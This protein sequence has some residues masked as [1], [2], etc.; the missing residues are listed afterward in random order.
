[1]CE[2]IIASC[3]IPILTV[4]KEEPRHEQIAGINDINGTYQYYCDIID[5]LYYCNII[6]QY[7]P[8]IINWRSYFI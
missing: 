3:F 1:M 2:S 5:Q 6:D 4:G 7:Y 8:N